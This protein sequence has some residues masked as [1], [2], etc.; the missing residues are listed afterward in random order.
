MES[1]LDVYAISDAGLHRA[2]NEDRCGA[3]V[4][5]DP[6]TQAERGRLFVVADG[7]GGHA[8]GDTASQLATTTI[9]QFLRDVRAEE[10]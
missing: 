10:P 2:R 4:A 8:G 1:S 7:M 9:Q 6:R 5:D 3:F